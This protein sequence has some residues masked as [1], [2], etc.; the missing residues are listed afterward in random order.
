HRLTLE[1]AGAARFTSSVGVEPDRLLAHPADADAVVDQGGDGCVRDRYS[2]AEE[3]RGELRGWQCDCALGAVPGD[4]GVV[5]LDPPML[6]VD[7]RE[8]VPQ[9]GEQP[10]VDGSCGFHRPSVTRPKPSALAWPRPLR[11]RSL[12]RFGST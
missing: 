1:V 10:Q 7:V 4:G 3:E 12:T 11:T 9:L 2:W 6:Q 5:A 8:A